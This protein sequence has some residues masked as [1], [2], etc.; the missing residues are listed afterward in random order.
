MTLFLI[1]LPV[2]LLLFCRQYTTYPMFDDFIYF[3]WFDNTDCT[4]LPHLLSPSNGY[5]WIRPLALLTCYLEYLLFHGFMAGY[6]IAGIVWH[7]ANAILV[8]K[9]ARD[10]LKFPAKISEWAGLLFILHPAAVQAVCYPSVRSET[11]YLTFT[12]AAL[13]LLTRYCRSPGRHYVFISGII[14]FWMALMAKETAFALIPAA[15]AWLFFA[16]GKSAGFCKKVAVSSILTSCGC[17]YMWLRHSIYQGVGGYNLGFNPTQ[18][19]LV[20]ITAGIRKLL[21][22]LPV[23]HFLPFSPGD[24]R[25]P[26]LYSAVGLCLILGLFRLAWIRR[27]S[28]G[29]FLAPLSLLMISGSILISIF[30]H[31]NALTL[32]PRYLYLGSVAVALLLAPALWP[33]R[34]DNVWAIAVITGCWLYGQ[35]GFQRDFYRAGLAT[36][37]IMTTIDNYCYYLE[38]GGQIDIFNIP[39]TI[40]SICVNLSDEKLN[41]FNLE[42]HRRCGLAP[43]FD[44][45]K[46]QGTDNW[47]TYID[48]LPGRIGVYSDPMP[49]R[50]TGE[51]LVLILDVTEAWAGDPP[52][53][54][55]Y[56]SASTRNGSGK[57]SSNVS[58]DRL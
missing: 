47:L 35:I 29:G 54:F 9:I 53:T 38:K 57:K 6:R 23:V 12:M 58:G 14:C 39:D 52:M 43:R 28:L 46:G 50:R 3:L 26:T 11:M 20:D 45:S 18:V 15:I 55:H 10:T 30:L 51:S 4:T 5:L 37:Y 48:S 49:I 19:R 8:Y 13:F 7:S 2:S 22:D 40:G 42:G 16:C 25:F 36:R 33:I 21:I 41:A 17:L 34:R 1:Y 27:S 24:I 31:Y 56:D 44:M 32:A